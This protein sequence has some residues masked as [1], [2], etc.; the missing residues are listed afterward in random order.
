[1]QIQLLQSTQT[2]LIIVA[3]KPCRI[4]LGSWDKAAEHTRVRERHCYCCDLGSAPQQQRGRWQEGRDLHSVI[5]M[6]RLRGKLVLQIHGQTAHNLVLGCYQMRV[7]GKGVCIGSTLAFPLG[8]CTIG[9]SYV[10]HTPRILWI[11]HHIHALAPKLA[12]L[13]KA[14]H[15]CSCGKCM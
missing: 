3:A 5:I 15:I 11:I 7:E 14:M 8:D 4:A 9:T 10:I 6:G 2:Q 12:S 1:M 13:G